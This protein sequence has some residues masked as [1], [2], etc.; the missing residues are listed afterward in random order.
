[1]NEFDKIVINVIT[2]LLKETQEKAIVWEK[3][4]PSR[5]DGPAVSMTKLNATVYTTQ[6][7]DRR[8]QIFRGNSGSTILQICKP[9]SFEVSKTMESYTFL[10][11]LYRSVENQQDNIYDFFDDYLRCGQTLQ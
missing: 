7:K 6:I 10:D 8:L 1:M 9:H 2:K 3:I 4:K 11:A 5:P